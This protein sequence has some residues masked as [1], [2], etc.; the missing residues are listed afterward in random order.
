MIMSVEIGTAY[1]FSDIAG[2]EHVLWVC[3]TTSP[4]NDQVFI[5]APAVAEKPSITSAQL[6]SESG[7]KAWLLPSVSLAVHRLDL[8]TRTAAS[9]FELV[10]AD[11]DID[12]LMN[13][14]GEM[15]EAFADLHIDGWRIS[16][17]F[18]TDP[19]RQ[20]IPDIE[21]CLLLEKSSSSVSFAW[22]HDKNR[23]YALRIDEG[24]GPS[25]QQTYDTGDDSCLPADAPLNVGS[26]AIP[27]NADGSTVETI[28]ASEVAAIKSAFGLEGETTA[29]AADK[30]RKRPSVITKWILG[31]WQVA[32]VA[33][34]VAGVAATIGLLRPPQ[35][36]TFEAYES[37]A[38]TGVRSGGGVQ[39]GV[40]LG[41]RAADVDATAGYFVETLGNAGITVMVEQNS[42]G[43]VVVI[44]EGKLDA[45]ESLRELLAKEGIDLTDREIIE[46]LILPSDQGP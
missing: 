27:F 3:M 23:R 34:L 14:E 12:S 6:Q 42:A 17:Y 21:D 10:P 36:P 8:E 40:L 24:H 4:S 7:R 28:T 37:F 5:L 46:I 25:L 29:K 16:R 43:E 31:N 1:D 9:R 2:R 39:L 44:G 45:S 30:P 20:V 22:R 13:V 26:T 38:T 35:V 18:H 33:V 19:D 32:T 15:D 11:L 41:L